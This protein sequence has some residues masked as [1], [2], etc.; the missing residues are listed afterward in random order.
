MKRCCAI[1]LIGFV[2][3]NDQ[4]RDRRWA[5]SEDRR[6]AAKREICSGVWLALRVMRRR[7]VPTGTVGGRIAWTCQPSS[8]RDLLRETVAS[9]APIG[10]LKIGE[11]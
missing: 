2:S 3:A 5:S 4:G 8:S 9:L 1:F 7:A 10:M 6:S 11:R